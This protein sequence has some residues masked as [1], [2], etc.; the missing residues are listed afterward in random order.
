MR[1]CSIDAA[2]S[3]PHGGRSACPERPRSSRC[4]T[5]AGD[6]ERAP[7]E[8]ASVRFEDGFDSLFWTAR[9]CTLEVLELV[10]EHGASFGETPERE[11]KMLEK[12]R[13]LGRAGAAD[14][15]EAALRKRTRS[16]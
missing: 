5:R 16:G 7:P 11:A 14:A 10:L 9:D 1:A 8:G 12:L 6:S 13:K 2:P 4:G 3:P 15:I